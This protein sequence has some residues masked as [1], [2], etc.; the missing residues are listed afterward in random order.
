MQWARLSM[1]LFHEKKNMAG[2]N[3]HKRSHQSKTPQDAQ[4][5]C[6]GAYILGLRW[7]PIWGGRYPRGGTRYSHYQKNHKRF[8]A[9]SSHIRRWTLW[10]SEPIGR[11]SSTQ[12]ETKDNPTCQP[13]FFSDCRTRGWLQEANSQLA[14]RDSSG[15]ARALLFSVDIALFRLHPNGRQLT[16]QYLDFT[17]SNRGTK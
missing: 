10:I 3:T 12:T 7:F 17:K 6:L 2:E 5:R 4:K 8:L 9:H 1:S 11:E 16:Y 13:P 14:I 15:L